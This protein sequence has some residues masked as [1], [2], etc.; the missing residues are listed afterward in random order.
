MARWY[1]R[2]AQ[3]GRRPLTAAAGGDEREQLG[4]DGESKSVMTGYGPAW[5]APQ[6]RPRS[7]RG[8]TRGRRPGGD[9]HFR[10]PTKTLRVEA[11]YGGGQGTT[12]A[13]NPVY[14]TRDARLLNLE[15]HQARTKTQKAPFEPYPVTECFYCGREGHFAR[16]CR[17]KQSDPGERR[18][19]VSRCGRHAKERWMTTR[20][21]PWRL[22]DMANETG[23]GV[24][25]GNDRV[26]SEAGDGAAVLRQQAPVGDA[27]EEM[28][29]G[30]GVMVP[31]AAS[32]GGDATD[33]VS[34]AY[35]ARGASAV[36]PVIA[37]V[38]THG[39][40]WWRVATRV[41]DQDE[42]AEVVEAQ[43]REWRKIY[44]HD[45]VDGAGQQTAGRDDDSGTPRCVEAEM[46]TE[47]RRR[48]EE[49]DRVLAVKARD[50]K[51]ER[52]RAE[53]AVRW[54]SKRAKRVKR[55]KA[56]RLSTNNRRHDGGGI[57]LE[58]DVVMPEPTAEFLRA[59]GWS[60]TAARLLGE[61]RAVDEALKVGYAALAVAEARRQE[62]L[63]AG[64]VVGCN[65]VRIGVAQQ[66]VLAAAGLDAIG[67]SDW[68]RAH[69]TPLQRS[70]DLRCA[71][72]RRTLITRCALRAQ[73][74]TATHPGGAYFEFDE[75][76]GSGPS[77]ARGLSRGESE[78]RRDAM[79]VY[80]YRSG[81]VY[82][83]PSVKVLSK[84]RRPMRVGQL[85]AVQVP[86]VVALPTARVEV[87]GE[88]REIKLDTGA[89]YSV[90]GESWRSLV[91]RLNVLPPVD[92]V[93]GF[94]GAVS[95]VRGVWRFRFR[96]Q[97]EQAVVDAL[98]VE[99][100]TTEFLL[101]E[102]WMLQ[103]GVKIDF[104]ACEMKW[105]CCDEKR[106]VPFSC[107]SDGHDETATKVRMVRATKGMANTC[108]R[109]ELA[110]AAPEGTT[111]LLMLPDA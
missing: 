29:Y 46:T 18:K 17:L 110:V 28:A 76:R 78:A 26:L 95:K 36:R 31:V 27:K 57:V 16:D 58:S 83:H 88:P 51:R 4:I 107:S 48:D 82:A 100:A 105:F 25:P 53:E 3:Q 49:R 55:T 72:G 97:Y 15:R 70:R 84:G 33:D 75:S 87:G 7:D 35:R 60:A 56:R 9:Q 40:C 68:T 21:R 104:T 11:K 34:R 63:A 92:Y 32:L 42:V 61:L 54:E 64:G 45:T 93:E 10:R 102:D 22:R 20:R 73:L 90:A 111:G 38:L 86:A 14:A 99:G 85:R 108:R 13:T 109:V 41:L 79:R 94:T 59:L 80:Q 23:D 62:V 8:G 44:E 2:E 91:E 50:E 66:L 52:T 67:E 39:T 89:Q 96:T 6:K 65:D 43:L 47:L 106:I 19:G 98:V 30:D 81:S 5:G 12:G 37:S 101:G 74:A 1:E 69:E 71:Y 24:T 77:A 103:N